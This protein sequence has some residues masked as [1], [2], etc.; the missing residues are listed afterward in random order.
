[1]KYLAHVFFSESE[2]RE[3]YGAHIGLEN[4]ARKGNGN[5][6]TICDITNF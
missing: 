3:V 4:F 5:F 6:I 2:I 1:V